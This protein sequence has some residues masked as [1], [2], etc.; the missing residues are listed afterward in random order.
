MI[1]YITAHSAF[2]QMRNEA[3]KMRKLGPTILITGSNQSGK[4]TIC[5]IFVNYSLRL[6]WRPVLVDL[7]LNNNEITPPG[8]IAA[9]TVDESIPNDDLI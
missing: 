9:C 2:N 4:S 3:L 6:G 5:K 1:E 8:C 7:D